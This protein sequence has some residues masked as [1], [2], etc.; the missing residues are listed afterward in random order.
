MSSTSTA[1][2]NILEPCD[3]QYWRSPPGKTGEEAE[4]VLDLKCTSILDS[5]SIINGFESFGIKT[6]TL[7]GARDEKGPWNELY[8]G[9]VAMGLEI[10]EEAIQI[11]LIQ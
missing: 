5:F 6:V 7:F 8:Q 1:G 9:D 11:L 4:L 2:T 10:T 3:N